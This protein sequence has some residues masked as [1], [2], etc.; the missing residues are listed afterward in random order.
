MISGNFNGLRNETRIDNV[1]FF[2]LVMRHSCSWT[3]KGMRSVIDASK[4]LRY[5]EA[6]D[7]KIQESRIKSLQKGSRVS[8]FGFLIEFQI[9]KTFFSL[10]MS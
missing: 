9:N 7:I 3:T 10:N 4:L 8:Q 2:D 5:C 1:W 6:V